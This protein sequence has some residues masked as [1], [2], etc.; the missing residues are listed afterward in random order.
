MSITVIGTIERRDIGTG[1]PNGGVHWGI[2]AA[3]LA[4]ILLI[5]AHEANE[6][7]RTFIRAHK[8]LGLTILVQGGAGAVGELA[9]QF[10]DGKAQVVVSE[11]TLSA[12]RI[13]D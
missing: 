1:G 10:A 11:T 2:A 6:G 13:P 8:A 4:Q 5:T 9:I 3:V 12:P 7:T